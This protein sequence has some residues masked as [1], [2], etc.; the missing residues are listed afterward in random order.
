MSL[1]RLDGLRSLHLDVDEDAWNTPLSRILRAWGLEAKENG[2][3]K[4][5]QMIF[6][7]DIGTS[8]TPCSLQFFDLFP[9][10]NTVGILTTRIPFWMGRKQRGQAWLV[11]EE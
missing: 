8:R 10:L 9:A 7:V 1:A 6:L 11:D 5:L 2:A 3:F 4:H